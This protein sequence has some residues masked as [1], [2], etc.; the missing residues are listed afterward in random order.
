MSAT[1]IKSIGGLR[2][3]K[4]VRRSLE[5]QLQ[6]IIAIITSWSLPYPTLFQKSFLIHYHHAPIISN[7]VQLH[8]F[9]DYT[10]LMPRWIYLLIQYYTVVHPSSDSL[11][12]HI[13]HNSKLLISTDRSKT[14]NKS[15][16]SWIIALQDE[17]KL[18]SGNNPGFGRHV[19]INSYHSKIYASLVSLVF[20]EYYCDSFFLPLNNT[21]HVTCD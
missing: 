5:Y 12:Y 11:L 9:T 19:D 15:G 7:T 18:V 8:D 3:R 20:L 21:I 16:G 4:I 14:Y 2:Q 6:K 13:C 17:T 10:K 1:I